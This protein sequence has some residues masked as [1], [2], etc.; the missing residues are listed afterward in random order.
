MNKGVLQT[1]EAVI[2]ILMTL[3]FFVI[4]F[5]PREGLPEFETISWKLRGFNALKILDKNNELRQ[6]AMANNT[7]AI[8]E[9]LQYL[10]PS[11]LNYE[12]VIC[13]QSCPNPN[14]EAEKLASVNYIIAGNL[15]SIRP[16]LIVLYVW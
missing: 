2:A 8:K 10:L 5:A 7:Q 9:R 14:I 16:I 3:T 4:F 11:N 15:T 6:Y 12:V 13:E 1:L